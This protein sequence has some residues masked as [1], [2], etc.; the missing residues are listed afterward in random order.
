MKKEILKKDA[1]RKR[2]AGEDGGERFFQKSL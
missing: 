2:I 1:L